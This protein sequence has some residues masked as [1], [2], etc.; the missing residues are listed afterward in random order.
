MQVTDNHVSWKHP[1]LSPLLL[2]TPSTC[3]SQIQCRYMFVDWQKK[4]T[5][6]VLGASLHTTWS[7][8]SYSCT[9]NMK[10]FSVLLLDVAKLLANPQTILY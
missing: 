4:N 10:L 7:E 5:D 9:N 2:H 8:Y 6:R 3:S 1:G